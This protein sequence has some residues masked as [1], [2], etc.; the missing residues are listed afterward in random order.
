MKSVRVTS[1]LVCFAMLA[2]P[3]FADDESGEGKKRFKRMPPD[4]V[5]EACSASVEGDPCSFQ[6]RRDETVSGTCINPPV[7]ELEGTLVCRPDDMPERRLR[8]RGDDTVEQS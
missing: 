8:M 2:A 5:F 4:V 3:A 1:A 7:E 6:G